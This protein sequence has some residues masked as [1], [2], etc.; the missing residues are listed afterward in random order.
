MDA[1]LL[2]VIGFVIVVAATVGF[3]ASAIRAA[4]PRGFVPFLVIAGVWLAAL[5][6]LAW[7]GA[8][9]QLP[10]FDVG[11]PVLALIVLAQLVP[12]TRRFCDRLPMPT[13]IYLQVV[14]AG[15]ELFLFGLAIGHLLPSS[16]TFAGHNFDIIIGFTAPLFG[17]LGFPGGRPARGPLIIWNLVGLGFL[18]HVVVLVASAQPHV[19]LTWPWIWLPGFV[20]PI[21]AGSH[22]ITLRRLV[23]QKD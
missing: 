11:I 21:V 2:L 13:L 22:L 23:A 20:V 12:A 17:N 18:V 6:V 5:P 3:A 10:L 16:V 14:R 15:V 19:I 8:F 9:D 4:S 7:R 1:G